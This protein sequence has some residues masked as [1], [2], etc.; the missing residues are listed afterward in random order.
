MW[1]TAIKEVFLGRPLEIS[2]S[3]S[4]DE[5]LD[6]LK[7]QEKHTPFW[8]SNMKRDDLRVDFQK[9][10]DKQFFFRGDRPNPKTTVECLVTAEKSNVKIS[11][12]VF[13]SAGFNWEPLLGVFAF[14]VL[15]YIFFKIPIISIVGTLWFII[16]ILGGVFV[17]WLARR[18]QNRLYDQIYNA[19]TN[20]TATKQKNI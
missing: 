18:N 6:I 17:L 3:F 12:R 1:T 14:L 16:S 5:V 2:T 4:L 11:G 7:S 19:L 8:K 20:P 9:H 13:L 10:T 15:P